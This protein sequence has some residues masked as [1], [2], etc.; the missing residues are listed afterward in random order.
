M[1]SGTFMP[2]VEKERAGIYFRFTSSAQSLLTDGVR[3][4]TVVPVAM[5]WGA[6]KAFTEITSQTDFLDKLGLDA[7]DPSLLLVK[8]AKKKSQKVLVYRLNNGTKA[9]ATIGTGVTATAVHPG[10]LGNNIRLVVQTNVLDSTKQ[11]V[12]VY[13]GTMQADKQTVS[14]ASQL[15]ANKWVTFSGTGALTNTAGVSLS[16]GTD[17]TV[18]NQDYADFFAAAESEYFNTIALPVA[19]DTEL[20]TTFASFVKRLRDNNG[21]K[22]VGVVAEHASDHEGIIN[23]T[24]G[25]V[26]GDGTVLTPAQ[27]TAW[28]AGASAGT[29]MYQS[30]TFMEYEGAVDVA[31]R[32]DNDETIARL[33]KGEFMLTFNAREKTVSV[34]QDIN[35]FVSFTSEKNRRFS[36]NKIIRILDSIQMDLIANLRAMIKERK[37]RGQDIPANADGAQIVR[38]AVTIYLSELQ[39]GGALMN[40]DPQTDITINLTDSADGFYINVGAQPVDAA[41]KFYFDMEV[42]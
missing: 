26:L 25:A 1:N 14:N 41:E 12:T 7:S 30:L 24:N 17:G 40:F 33:A 32:Y 18:T 13:G 36:K 8:E 28:V 19:S 42:R 9:T 11:D 20:K 37:E 23:V 16:T 34:E 27:T 35:S 3:G 22:I 39:A 29:T 2:G 5:K 4:I 6:A 31:P 38:T 10:T 15:K 21:V